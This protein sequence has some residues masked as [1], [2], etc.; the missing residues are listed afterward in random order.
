MHRKRK[1]FGKRLLLL[2]LLV[3]V[4]PI[5]AFASSS[6]GADAPPGVEIQ[7]KGP[8][9]ASQGQT[10]RFD[11]CEVANKSTDALEDFY[12]HDRL[13]TDAVRIKSLVTGKFNESLYYK[14]S[15]RTNLRG[16][17][18]LAAYLLTT[19]SYDLCLH[20]NVLGLSDGEY[21]KDIRFE[22]PKVYPGFKSTGSISLFC[23][24]MLTVPKDYN[25]VNRADL[26]GRFVNDWLSASASW[27]TK[28]GLS[29]IHTVK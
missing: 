20:P 17:R 29:D 9:Q 24:V 6:D 28:A 8:D 19:N 4:C 14:I 22:F 12:I 2:F 26:G 13:P 7:V 21:I 16:Y 10:I 3:A 25:I 18:V 11:L 1:L 5:M 27:D 23:D 15:Y